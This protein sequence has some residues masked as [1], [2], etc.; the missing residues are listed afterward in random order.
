MLLF[1]ELFSFGALQ[2]ILSDESYLQY[3]LDFESALAKAQSHSNTIPDQ[4]AQKI[5]AQCRADNF[6]LAALA[7]QTAQSGNL[8]IPLIK[9]LTESV[10]LRDPDAARFVHWGATSQDAIDTAAILQLRDTLA[11]IENDLHRL[12]E[13]LATLANE[14]RKTPIVARTW[15]QQALPTTFGF[16]VAGWLDA[17]LRH[18]QRLHESRPG[19]LTLQFGGAVGTLAALGPNGPKV[20][21]ALAQEL[22]LTLPETPWHT[23]RDRIAEA[24]ALLGLLSGTLGKIARDISLHSQTEIAELSEPAVESRGSSS[25]MPHKR[26]PVTCA[27]VLQAAIRVPG[28]V[29]TILSVMPQEYQR[30]LGLWH[31]EWETLPEILRLTGG[32]LH[33]LTDMLP[34]LLVDKNRMRQNLELTHGL[35]FSEAVSIALAQHI[36]KAAAHQL[37]ESASQKAIASKR[38]LKD[39]LRDEPS[40]RTHLS[41][42]DLT[43]LFDAK[44]YLGSAE[45]FLQQVVARARAFPAPAAT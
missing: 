30:S 24:A 38:H 7:K 11:L 2:Q 44:N 37:L 19:I 39:V 25:T 9:S 5:T 33:H 12:T 42:E 1:N 45:Q 8:A 28:L 36:G 10:S 17:I 31:A 14:H 23:H 32:A 16:I 15:T 18:R 27:I 34:H 43:R 41:D 40:L 29:S 22:H 6:D 3:L 13:I 20:A 4:V 26:N 35:I 21:Q